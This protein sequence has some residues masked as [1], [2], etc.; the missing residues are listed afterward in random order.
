MKF[1]EFNKNGYN[2]VKWEWNVS[3]DLEVGDLIQF[4]NGGCK[5]FGKVLRLWHNGVQVMTD[6]GY[7]NPAWEHVQRI[8]VKKKITK[9]VSTKL[10]C[11]LPDRSPIALIH[12][13]IDRAIKESAGVFEGDE[14]FVVDDVC[15]DKLTAYSRQVI[16]TYGSKD[17]IIEISDK[18][19]T[20]CVVTGTD[21]RKWAIKPNKQ[22]KITNVQCKNLINKIQSLKGE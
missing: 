9:I 22:N 5:R 18:H 4:K 8:F 20:E 16:I 7:Y 12:N 6:L 11:R 10:A 21:I 13:L 15:T 14:D 17:L 2:S 19:Q 1:F 3:A